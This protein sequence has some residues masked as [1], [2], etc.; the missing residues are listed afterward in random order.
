MDVKD[1]VS[2]LYWNYVF[3]SYLIE[4]GVHSQIWAHLNGGF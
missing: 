4:F 1:D 2:D 3:Y